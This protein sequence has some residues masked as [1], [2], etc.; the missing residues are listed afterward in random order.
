MTP[1]FHA[2]PA[3]AGEWRSQLTPVQS[4]AAGDTLEA[5]LIIGADGS[6]SGTV[7]TAQVTGRIANNRSWFGRLMNWRDDYAIRGILSQPVRP[8]RDVTA[9]R[10]AGVLAARDRRLDG[11]LSL[12]NRPLRV[13]LVK[14]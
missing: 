8:Y 6:L 10:F 3:L 13:R 1:A 4:A 9:D 11:V 7:G 14:H 5:A 12:A 2:T